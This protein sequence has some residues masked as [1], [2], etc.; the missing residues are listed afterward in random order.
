MLWSS[1]G[2]LLNDV[3]S[4]RSAIEVVLLKCCTTS[5]VLQISSATAINNPD[6]RKRIAVRALKFCRIF[7]KFEDL[8]LCLV[9]I[10]QQFLRCFT[11]PV[12]LPR[13]AHIFRKLFF[14]VIGLRLLDQLGNRGLSLFILLLNC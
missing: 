3:A 10:F 7:A 6:F 13:L 2:V 8:D 5:I 11:E 12:D 9:H 1:T 4:D 14:I